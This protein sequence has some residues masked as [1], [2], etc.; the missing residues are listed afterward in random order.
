[1]KQLVVFDIDGTLANCEHRMHHIKPDPA[2]DPVTGRKVKRRFD[3]FHKACVD[4][5]PITPVVDIFLR[6]VADPNVIVVLLT[7]RP[8]SARYDTTQWF[9]KHGLDGY[10]ELFTKP[11]GQDMMPDKQQKLMIAEHIEKKY[12]MPISMVF[13]DRSRVVEMWKER[14]TFVLNVEQKPAD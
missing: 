4:D 7:G 10:D 8:M 13:E 11:S 2:I 3:L 14:G 5:T 9:T 12:G 1:M 6:M